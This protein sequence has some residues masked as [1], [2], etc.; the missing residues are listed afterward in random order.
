MKNLCYL[1]PEI[2]IGDYELHIQSRQNVVLILK[3]LIHVAL[4]YE[5]LSKKLYRYQMLLSDYNHIIVMQPLAAFQDSDQ[6]EKRFH[7]YCTARRF[8]IP[9]KATMIERK[10][11]GSKDEGHGSY[12]HWM[13]SAAS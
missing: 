12:Y 11:F 6:I 2:S 8:E 5:R 4:S 10:P 3:Y 13:L 1:V 9:R 7:G